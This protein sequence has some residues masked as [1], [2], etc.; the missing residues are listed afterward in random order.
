VV[1]NV[2]LVKAKEERDRTIEEQKCMISKLEKADQ[3]CA[4]LRSQRDEA[5][6]ENTTLRNQARDV[7]NAMSEGAKMLRAS[8]Q[9]KDD[10]AQQAAE[11][12]SLRTELNQV[13]LQNFTLQR[14]I[15]DLQFI[16]LNN[17]ENR[18]QLLEYGG[19]ANF[20]AQ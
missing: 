9:Q 8:N 12:A 16:I 4:R 14:S 3:E 18:Q 6:A 2:A 17:A 13:R 5:R 1:E 20:S 7:H 19:G 11:T 10:M 15:Y